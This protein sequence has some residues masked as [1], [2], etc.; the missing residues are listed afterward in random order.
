VRVVAIDP[1]RTTGL[2][3]WRDGEEWWEPVLQEDPLW[4]AIARVHLALSQ[5]KLDQVVCEDFVIT[6][7]TAKKSR[8]TSALDGLG[9]TRYLTTMYDVPL[10]IYRTAEAKAFASDAT[11]RRI[12]WYVKGQSHARDASRH[13]LLYLVR[14][15]VVAPERVLR[16]ANDPTGRDPG[17]SG[18]RGRAPLRLVGGR[19]TMSSGRRP[20]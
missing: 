19:D 4:V 7:Q 8:E 10:A 2:A 14:S 1:G 9:T 16:P 6:T 17:T 12:G 3:W 11:L 15:G 5:R 20:K 13:L 18:K